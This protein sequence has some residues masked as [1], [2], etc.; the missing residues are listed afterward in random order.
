MTEYSKL[1]REA[2]ELP[3]NWIPAFKGIVTTKEILRS[4]LVKENN[5]PDNWCA[6]VSIA[7]EIITGTNLRKSDKTLWVPWS[8]KAW[9][10]GG[11]DFLIRVLRKFVEKGILE[12]KQGGE[13]WW[14]RLTKE[15]REMATAKP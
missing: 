4:C 5:F 9:Q 1:T 13:Y 7:L 11:S 8:E 2:K 15:G 3:E 12:E 14:W 10:N 6:D